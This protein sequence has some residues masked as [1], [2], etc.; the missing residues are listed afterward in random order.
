M[1]EYGNSI[2]CE[3]GF[4]NLKENDETIGFQ[5]RVRVSYYRSIPF[6]LLDGYEIV[7]DGETFVN[8]DIDF[9]LDGKTYYPVTD[10][11]NYTEER[12]E[13][14]DK[15]YLRIR[16]PGGLARGLHDVKVTQR[17]NVPYLPFATAFY[18]AKRLTIV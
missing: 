13:Y 3:Q 15:A 1:P 11:G 14:G 4:K 2:L 7:V 9:S 12:W 17:I 6:S 8:E 5:L 10:L 16:K 18:Q